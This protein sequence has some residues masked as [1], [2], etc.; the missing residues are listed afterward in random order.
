MSYA[1][2]PLPA[3]SALVLT[4]LKVFYPYKKDC[5]LLYRAFVFSKINYVP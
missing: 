5:T 4:V 3:V 2:V 1:P